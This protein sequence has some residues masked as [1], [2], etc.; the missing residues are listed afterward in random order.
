MLLRICLLNKRA[1]ENYIW[2]TELLL[3]PWCR[4]KSAC[5]YTGQNAPSCG[6]RW[7][8][9][10]GGGL[11]LLKSQSPGLSDSGF[12]VYLYIAGFLLLGWFWERSSGG[13]FNLE[14]FFPLLASR[15]SLPTGQTDQ[16]PACPE[17]E[18][19][20]DTSISWGK[21]PGRATEVLGHRR[22]RDGGGMA[23]R[24]GRVNVLDIYCRA[25]WLCCQ[26]SQST[27]LLVKQKE[28]L[29]PNE[30]ANQECRVGVGP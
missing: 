14:I 16:E 25:L 8:A 22:W 15:F 3:F 13:M 17:Q 18:L 9:M 10:A 4:A 12:D 29:D 19:L 23:G 21:G 2:K 6:L 1:W 5:R 7:E 27:E 11:G 20:T 30:R 26:T 24:G 28:K